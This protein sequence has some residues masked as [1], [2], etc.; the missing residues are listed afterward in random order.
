MSQK[1][2]VGFP[3]YASSLIFSRHRI[4]PN[5]FVNLETLAEVTVNSNIV[6]HKIKWQTQA[7]TVCAYTVQISTIQSKCNVN[8]HTRIKTL[9]LTVDQGTHD[10]LN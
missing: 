10:N 4:L 7:Y 3:L 8:D 6:K 9:E 2:H 5:D 1:C